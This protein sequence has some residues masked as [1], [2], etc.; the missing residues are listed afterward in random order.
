MDEPTAVL[1]LNEINDLFTII[2]RELKAQGVAIIYISHH[3]EETFALADRITVLR[4]GRLVAT[5]P[6]AEMT[7]PDPPPT[8]PAADTCRARRLTDQRVP[9]PP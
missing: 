1:S 5:R 4:D 3:L 2:V 9:T 6:A 8:E 7:H